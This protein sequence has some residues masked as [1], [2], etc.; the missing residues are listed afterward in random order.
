MA[1]AVFPA[2]GLLRAR[3][4]DAVE[5]LYVACVSRWEKMQGKNQIVVTGPV[6]FN[7][8]VPGVVDWCKKF[9]CNY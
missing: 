6:V 8:P 4:G 9:S 5:C 1:D 3:Q 2:L 7:A